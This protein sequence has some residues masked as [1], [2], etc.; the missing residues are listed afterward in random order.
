MSATPLFV[1]QV[2]D[3][4][5]WVI[6]VRNN[7]NVT[8]PA[9]QVANTLPL[10][11]TLVSYTVTK[12]S[13]NPGTG[14]WAI[15]V[16]VPNEVQQM[17]LVT[18]VDDLAQA[19][20]INTAVISGT[21]IDPNLANNTLTDEVGVTSCPPA[22]GAVDDPGSCLCGTVSLNDTPCSHC[23]TRYEY[24]PL[25]LVNLVINTWDTATGQYNASLIDPLVS[26]TFE[27]SIWCDCPDGSNY[28]TSGPAV[29][30]INP[31]FV[32]A[33]C[34]GLGFVVNSG[35]TAVATDNVNGEVTLSVCGGDILHFYSSDGTVDIGVTVGSAVVDLK[36]N[37]DGLF[38]Q[39][40][41]LPLDC[42]PLAP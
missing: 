38:A 29:V 25:S 12:G 17:R 4:I 40:L 28:E 42:T 31:L 19:P 39:M 32:N 22:A 21:L 9:A 33:P 10:G 36:I 18:R 26:G 24:D 35:T 11:V 41:A 1:T 30:T 3:L 34:A 20:F 8:E 2:G 16:L 6:P 27:Y 15:G 5:H 14:I 23:T 7:G 37:L 13:F